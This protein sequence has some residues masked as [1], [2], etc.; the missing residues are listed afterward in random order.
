M[1][2]PKER[3]KERGEKSQELGIIKAVLQTLNENVQNTKI[4]T[5][6][7]MNESVVNANTYNTTRYSGGYGR[8]YLP[9]MY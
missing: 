5:T 4:G 2:G 3:K 1:T 6:I 9:D 8:I 7:Y